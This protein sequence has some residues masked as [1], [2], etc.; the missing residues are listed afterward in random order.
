MDLPWMT[1]IMKSKLKERSYLTKTYCKY[2]NRK[3]DFEKLFVKTNDC[4][5]IILAT[6]D[7]YIIRIIEKLNDPI[8]TP[9]IYMK[10]I[11]RF[12]SNKRIPAIPLLLV[13]G[14]ITS[15]FSQEASI[16]SDISASQCTPLQNSSI[17][18]TFYR[19]TEETLSS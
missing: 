18:L 19:T 10:I 2:G 5:A 12:L 8:M 3:S 9:K 13:N 1:D 15:N 7:K 14:E 16:V 6:K 11:N 17:L 4:V